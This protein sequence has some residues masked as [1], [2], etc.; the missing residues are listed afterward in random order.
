[1][2]TSKIL[3][4]VIGEYVLYFQNLWGLIS[5]I[6]LLKRLKRMELLEFFV[7]KRL[8]DTEKLSVYILIDFVK[9]V[10]FFNVFTL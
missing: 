6:R 7:L 4:I 2:D 9:T 3:V 8:K 5:V 1:M 10:C